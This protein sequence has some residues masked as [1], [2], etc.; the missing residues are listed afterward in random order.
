MKPYAGSDFQERRGLA[1]KDQENRI[2]SGVL[3][4]LGL[5]GFELIMRERP[6]ALADF[7]D[8]DGP[9]RLGCEIQ[10]L[11]GDS[12]TSGSPLREFESRWVQCVA[13]VRETLHADG[14]LVPYCTVRFRD[15]SYA[16]LRG[17]RNDQLVSELVVCGRRLRHASSLTFPQADTPQLNS[18]LTE[19]RVVDRDDQGCLWWPAH[20]QSG[21]V[22]SLDSATVDALRT[23]GA[24]AA[25]YEWHGS[26]ERWLLLVAEAR[27][28]TDLIGG[29]RKIDLPADLTLPFTWVLVWDRFSEDLW[30]IHPDYAVICDGHKQL[31]RA[32]L[33]PD[34]VR[35]FCTAGEVYATKPKA[36]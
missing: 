27:G 30:T 12:C 32:D 13:R 1:N 35:R 31:R 2:I 16:S 15:R 25:S 17:V 3:D 24:L 28:L 29:A 6:D 10:T 21:E 23:K 7:R 34:R 5:A 14:R 9:V 26:D 4:R 36:R 20:L 19:I 11:Q 33:L 18:L 8:A 22:P